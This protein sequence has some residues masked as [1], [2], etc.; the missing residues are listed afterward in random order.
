VGTVPYII[1]SSYLLEH[2]LRVVIIGAQRRDL[3]KTHRVESWR[4]N[5]ATIK[6]KIV[7]PH[8][9]SFANPNFSIPDPRSKRF[10]TPDPESHKRI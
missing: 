9:T 4:K 7:T 10:R 8:P 6:P 3:P 5:L 1:I 2:I